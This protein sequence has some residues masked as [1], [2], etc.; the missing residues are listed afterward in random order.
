[1]DLSST[2]GGKLTGEM[3][4]GLAPSAYITS[5]VS[6]PNTDMS[7]ASLVKELKVN[8]TEAMVRSVD[9]SQELCNAINQMDLYEWTRSMGKVPRMQACLER[10]P[11]LLAQ[12]LKSERLHTT[13]FQLTTRACI[14]DD[15]FRKKFSEECLS[16]KR[17]WQLLFFL[18]PPSTFQLRKSTRSSCCNQN[19]SPT[20]SNAT[21][22]LST[23]W[24]HL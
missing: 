5:G 24:F 2:L 21:M 15:Q 13:K 16:R 20:K 3:P 8:P 17:V 10:H 9:S 18:N 23:I 12:A 11:Y 7:V 4:V 14:T 1:V 22:T 19:C 6:N